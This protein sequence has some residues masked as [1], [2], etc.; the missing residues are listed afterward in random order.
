MKQYLAATFVVLMPA[1]AN[2]VPITYNYVGPYL[3]YPYPAGFPVGVSRITSTFTVDLAPNLGAAAVTPISWTMSDGA[4]T[5]TSAS[6][7]YELY[8]ADFWT[9]ALGEVIGYNLWAWWVPFNTVAHP[10]PLGVSYSMG[11]NSAGL[12]F[13]YYCVA[14]LAD[15]TCDRG[16]SAFGSAFGALTV[17]AVPEPGT[18]S[19]LGAGL[20]GL[21]VL[22]RRGASRTI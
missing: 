15:G 6:P 20:L 22:R 3:G 2:A 7:D 11:F 10:I 14:Q 18:L 1:I 9:N 8:A 19:L 17:Q 13:T 5:I 21:V 16:Q 4:T 12:A